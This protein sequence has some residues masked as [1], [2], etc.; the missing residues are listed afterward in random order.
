MTITE[1]PTSVTL[2]LAGDSGIAV[3]VAILGATVFSWRR[4]GVEHL[5]K[6]DKSKIIGPKAIRGGIP[7]CWPIFGPPPPTAQDPDKLYSKLSQHG[8]VRTSKWKF[9]KD[10]SVDKLVFSLESSP[11]TEAVFP[12]SFRLVYTVGLTSTTLT[13]TLSVRNPSETASL[14]FQALLHTYLRL[15]SPITPLQ[16]AITGLK[17][18]G[19]TDKVQ[20]GIVGTE[21]RD[22][23]GFEEGEVDRVYHRVGDH[24][25][26]SWDA[27]K[28]GFTINKKNLP[29]TTVWNPAQ[30]KGAAMGD[31]DPGGW[32]RYICVEP[33]HVSSLVSLAPGQGWVGTQYIS[34]L[35]E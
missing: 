28:T 35:G 7:I 12:R 27:G 21:S 20:G 13:T 26:V 3:S 34:V 22:Q 33:G 29:D 15:P 17:G 4:D 11:E 1:T 6:S 23:V 32:D 18:L 31:M 5:F 30:V 8:F 24:L 9:E 19:F 16:T 25:T 2:A 10:K 14:P